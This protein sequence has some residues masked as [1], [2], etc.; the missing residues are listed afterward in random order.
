[1]ELYHGGLEHH[2]P[3]FKKVAQISLIVRF[4]ALLVEARIKNVRAVKSNSRHLSVNMKLYVN[5]KIY[6]TGRKDMAWIK[7]NLLPSRCHEPL[8]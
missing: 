1:M 2:R 5:L 6:E 7:H 3:F 4:W 8:F